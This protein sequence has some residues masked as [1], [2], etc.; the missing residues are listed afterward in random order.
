MRRLKTFSYLEPATIEEVVRM[1]G[2][3]MK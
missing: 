2:E 3:G 1:R